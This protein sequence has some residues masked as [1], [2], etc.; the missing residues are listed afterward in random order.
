[1]NPPVLREARVRAE[2][3]LERSGIALKPRFPILERH[4]ME[5]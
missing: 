1:M 5:G 4:T 2:R 3:L